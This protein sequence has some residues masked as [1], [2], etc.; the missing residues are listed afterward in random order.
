MLFHYAG[1]PFED[2][3]ISQADWPNMKQSKFANH[4]RLTHNQSLRLKICLCRLHLNIIRQN[5]PEISR[6][7]TQFFAKFSFR[8]SIRE[9]ASVGVE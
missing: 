1:Q 8:V 5:F 6:F 4:S 9:I 7:E 2:I 3:R